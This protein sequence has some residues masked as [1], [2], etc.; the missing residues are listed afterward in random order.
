MADNNDEDRVGYGQPPKSKQFRPNQSGNPRGRPPKQERSISRRQFRRDVLTTLESPIT[1][2][3]D[4]KSRTMTINEAALQKLVHQ[5]FSGNFRA[6]SLLLTLRQDLTTEHTEA[7]PQ[8][9]KTLET[10][11]QLLVE[12]GPV[13]LDPQSLA[14][15]NDMRRKTRKI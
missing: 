12:D 9:S 10:G 14:V 6:L 1:L 13:R 7:H 2:T 11:E 4:G 15:Y 3:I 5:A 8:L